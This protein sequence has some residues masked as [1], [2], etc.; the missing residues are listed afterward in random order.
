MTCAG[1]VSLNLTHNPELTRPSLALKRINKNMTKQTKK[2]KK[3]YK[4]IW[5]GLFGHDM[6]S[7][8]EGI[9]ENG[10]EIPTK[11]IDHYYCRECD[12]ERTKI[13]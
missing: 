13:I 8:M 7:W 4:R 5:C 1:R 6:G 2:I 11:F 10:G 9:P 3:Y 12:Y